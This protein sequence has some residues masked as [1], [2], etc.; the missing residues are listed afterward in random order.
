MAVSKYPLKSGKYKGLTCDEIESKGDISY[1]EWF[2]GKLVPGLHTNNFDFQ[3]S[4]RIC[5]EWLLEK[6]GIK[7]ISNVPNEPVI[8]EEKIKTNRMVKKFVEQAFGR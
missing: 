7:S 1:I 5:N 3:Y 4:A 8:D 6:K 2:A